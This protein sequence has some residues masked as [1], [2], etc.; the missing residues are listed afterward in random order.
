MTNRTY[1]FVTRHY[2]WLIKPYLYMND[3]Y[4]GEPITV[5]SDIKIDLPAPH[6]FVMMPEY[7]KHF[8]QDRMGQMV[9]E[10]INQF[11]EPLATISLPDLWTKTPVDVD[12]VK[13]LGQHMMEN[14]IARGN[15]WAGA[16]AT[17]QCEEVV[18]VSERLSV[19]K[20]SP[21]KSQ[22]GATSGLL[23]MWSKKFLNDFFENDWTWANMELDGQRKFAKEDYDTGRRYSVA[24][25]PGLVDGAHIMYTSDPNMARITQVSDEDKG[26]IRK[27]IPSN[28]RVEE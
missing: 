18:E 27:W 22:I 20:V 17:D 14:P 28:F 4:W 16:Y 2:N 6:T 11:P 12:L 25:K 8:Y 3:K 15:L 7:C 13:Q 24:T 23:A 5:V 1:C 21:H 9:K 26:V 10:I 19:G